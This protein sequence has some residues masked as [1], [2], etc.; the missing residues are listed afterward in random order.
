M[1]VMAPVPTVLRL[2]LTLVLAII[3]ISHCNCRSY[4]IYQRR[5]RTRK[6]DGEKHE[7]SDSVK[8]SDGH[9]DVNDNRSKKQGVT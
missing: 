5:K 8:K 1:K 2:L 9:D 4:L 6:K 7:L 3:N